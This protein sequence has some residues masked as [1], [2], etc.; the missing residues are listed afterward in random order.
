MRSIQGRLPSLN[1]DVRGPS[2]TTPPTRQNLCAEVLADIGT[3]RDA[4]G[5]DRV[6]ESTGHHV[7]GSRL[8]SEQAV[9]QRKQDR[10]Q[11]SVQAHAE[12]G[13]GACN[14]IDLECASCAD[15]VGR[16]AHH[17]THHARI[18]DAAEATAIGSQVQRPLALVVVGG[19]LL[20][21]SL[22]LLALPVLI[23]LF[24]RSDRQVTDSNTVP[25]PAE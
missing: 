7:V 13:K 11:H 1:P 18:L 17:Q 4:A 2:N 21:P 12:T 3:C 15:S 6:C 16:N 9:E 23:G 10:S 24:S 5:G 19:I 14:F 8:R 20:T 25:E 22:V